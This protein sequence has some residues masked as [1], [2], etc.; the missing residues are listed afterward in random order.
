MVL[1][2][3][4]AALASAGYQIEVAENGADALR[5][6]CK[7]PGRFSLIVADVLMP[8]MG[9]GELAAK[10]LAAQPT[11]KILFLS[12]Y[13]DVSTETGGLRLPLLRKPFLPDQLR[14]AVRD[15]LHDRES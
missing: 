1:R 15:L 11:M 5:L 6:F 12:G 3:A 10:V 7:R 2:S 8:V 4:S 13:A 9:G 14:S